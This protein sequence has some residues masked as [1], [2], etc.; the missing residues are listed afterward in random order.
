M[1]LSSHKHEQEE[2]NM[3]DLNKASAIFSEW[4]QSKKYQGEKMP[5]ELWVLAC[6]MT[7][8]HPIE[9]VARE[10]RITCTQ[11][12]RRMELSPNPSN[13]G[14]SKIEVRPFPTNTGA[15]Q[16]SIQAGYIIEIVLSP[17]VSLRVPSDV[18]EKDLKSFLAMALE[19][20]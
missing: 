9:V 2:K 15:V 8:N 16:T 18:T 3:F 11:L 19:V 20:V 4:R 7:K 1:I 10:L 12:R 14:Q 6:S 13:S 5:D 17:S